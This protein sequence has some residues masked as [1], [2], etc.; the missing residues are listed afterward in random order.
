MSE[1][2]VITLAIG[3]IYYLNLSWNLARSFRC[4]HDFHNVSFH[5]ITDLDDVPWPKDLSWVHRRV[6]GEG[7]LGIG[8]SC[9][10]QLDRLAPAQQTLFLDA[11][12]LV[13]GS[14]EPVFEQMQGRSVGVVGGKIQKGEWFGDI[15]QLLQ[16]LNLSSL[17]KFNGG[18]YYLEPG[19]VCDGVFARARALEPQYDA[20]GLLRLRNRPND[21]LLMS[22][23]MAEAGLTAL[24]DDGSILG[25]PQACQVKLRIDVPRGQCQLTNPPAYNPL[26]QPW[27]PVG[28]ISP[29]VVHFLAHHTDQHPYRT[30][31]I[32][33]ALMQRDSWPRGL[34]QLAAE[35]R[36][37]MPARLR[38][39]V[40]N[41]LRPIYRKLCG[42][43]SVKASPRL[44]S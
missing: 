10:L 42:V 34:A 40:K 13:C 24:V 2:A 23:A 30:Q 1:K 28:T 32:Q 25:D 39:W 6:V 37:G 35:V 12:C 15:G 21:E 9:K 8:F 16:K 3:S 20:L 17:P 44:V 38:T 14:L 41:L 29:R 4:W 7:A 26:H 22:I 18:L 27:Y 11:D 5:I 36:F 31:E 19:K 33:L 43:R